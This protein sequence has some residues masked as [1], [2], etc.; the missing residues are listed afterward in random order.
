MTRVLEL[1]FQHQFVGAQSLQSCLIL[2]DP[3]HCNLQGSSLHWIFLERILEWVPML[4]SSES[5]WPRD[6]THISCVSCTAGRLFYH[7]ATR[8][9]LSI[10]P[11]KEYSEL[12]SFRADWFSHLAVQGTLKSLFQHHNSKASILWCSALFVVPTLI[13]ICDYWRKP[14]FWLHRHLLSKWY[15][16]F[17]IC[18][19]GLS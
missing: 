9:T 6:W 10:S 11:F 8:E 15:L 5:S 16:C 14:Y 12:I 7:W 17:L 1:Q 3:R 2:W 18:C 13:Y 4:S 19:L